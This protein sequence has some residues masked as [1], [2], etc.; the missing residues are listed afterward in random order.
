MPKAYSD[1]WVSSF[2][3]YA[4]KVSTFLQSSVFVL[5]HKLFLEAHSFPRALLS[6][7]CSHLGTDSVR[8]QISVHIFTPNGSYYFYIYNIHFSVLRYC[9]VT[10]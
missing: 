3:V 7:N 2:T 10:M 8:G 4:F 6:V 1:H 9:V 5:E